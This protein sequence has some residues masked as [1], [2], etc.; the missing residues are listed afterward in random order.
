[1]GPVVGLAAAAGGA[2]LATTKGKGGDIARATGDAAADVG[3][4]LQ[5]MDKK[6]HISEKATKSIVKS[7]NWVSKQVKPKK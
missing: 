5:K 3:A 7:A 1:M 6:H 2:V 4:R